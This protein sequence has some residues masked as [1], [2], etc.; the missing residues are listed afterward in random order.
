LQGSALIALAGATLT[1]ARAQCLHWED[2]FSHVTPGVVGY[3]VFPKVSSISGVGAGS[4]AKVYAIGRFFAAGD[5]NVPGLARW[6]GSHWSA[7]AQTI[8]N[9]VLCSS[10][11]DDGSGPALYIGG[12]MTTINGVHVDNI[13]R[14]D[15]S[16][17]SNAG[18]APG[19]INVLAALDDGSGSA[20]Y[21]ARSS[22]SPPGLHVER[23]T[24]H[25]WST[26]PGTF[27]GGIDA[28]TV[29]D[30]GTGPALYVGGSFTYVDATFANGI[31]RW[32]GSYWAPL[33]NG[34]NGIVQ[35]LRVY[36][37]GNGNALYAGGTFTAADTVA[38]AHVARW[39]GSSWTALGSGTNG[40][41]FAL[42]TFDGGGGSALIAG[43]QFTSAG[44]Q[45][46]SSIASWNGSS[47]ASVGGGLR[48]A[49]PIGF[50][51]YVTTLTTLDDGR[52]AALYAGGSFQDAGGIAAESIARWDGNAWSAAAPHGNGAGG[53]VYSLLVHDDGGGPALFAGGS[54]HEIGGI[55]ANSIAKWNGASW[56]PL[57]VGLFGN[58]F[59]GVVQALANLDVGT[60]HTLIA[61]G[62]FT[63]AGAIS[64]VGIA[65]W[66]GANWSQLGGS[67]NGPVY[68]LAIDDTATGPGLFAGGDFDSLGQASHVG[69]I[70][71]W[72]GVAWEHV[73]VGMNGAV[74]ALA[75]FD[76]GNG[77][78]LYASGA[79]STAGG[80]ITS[81]VARWNPA[82]SSWS[83]LQG[84]VNN[85]AYATAVFDDGSGNALYVG[86]A[87]SFAGGISAHGVARWN[88]SSWAPVGAGL[89]H[90]TVFALGVFDDGAGPALYAGGGFTQSG[91]VPIRG[92]ANWDGA[93]WTPLGAGM[94][95]STSS[96]VRALA[97]VD[98]GSGRGAELWAGGDFTTAGANPSKHVAVW[99]G[100]SAS[101]ETFCFGDGSVA[102]CP[103][104][105]SGHL[106]RGCE[107]SASTGGA[108]LS[109]TGTTEPDRIVLHAS[110]ELPSALAIFLQGDALIP[111]GLRFGD[112]LLCSG[113][114]LMRLFAKSA[115]S[116]EVAAPEIGDES[117]T[118]R[119]AAL[120]DPIAPGATRYYQTYYRD[121]NLAFCPPPQGDSWNVTNGIK[122]VW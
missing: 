82:T 83:A 112:G 109:A 21:T 17:W 57:S 19:I 5:V 33:G 60:V 68:S 101:V 30:D 8:D 67:A 118:A 7:P 25:V 122:V 37:D 12:S 66:D 41:V 58:E 50:T 55:V 102:Q 89:D 29:F 11:W 79:F 16:T 22:M 114:D 15:G 108:R 113:G 63:R 94:S 110:G 103:C 97:S 35:A 91:G 28:M 42:E 100:C 6:D 2:G 26:L 4:A 52:G 119:S 84:G 78:S 46:V 39:D 53:N 13:A 81:G 18:H 9:F 120:G 86:G 90:G 95:F 105:N 87:F 116:G 23:L 92:I 121:P 74:N 69:G 45:S 111:S 104:R 43:G 76:D 59:D 64:A 107:N 27:D 93:N 10:V 72:N 75:T 85:D 3:E 34:T 40:V 71:R 65:S 117:I 24:N 32:T 88:G 54:F 51:P 20:L 1:V 80:V 70:A 49:A 47:W 61:A 77:K 44:G 56:S 48:N 14:Y 36:D 96:I 106:E 73:G 62:S 99:R 98:T 115:T 38:A 31:A